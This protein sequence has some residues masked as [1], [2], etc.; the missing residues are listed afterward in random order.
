ML[1]RLGAVA[2]QRGHAARQLLGQSTKRSEGRLVLPTQPLR[3]RPG[4]NLQAL[5]RLVLTDF[6][7]LSFDGASDL[8]AGGHDSAFAYPECFV[9]YDVRISRMALWIR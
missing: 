1:R 6:S 7:E 5:S 3:E 4:W 9:K 2:D 8:V